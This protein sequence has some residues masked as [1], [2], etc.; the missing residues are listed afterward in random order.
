MLLILCVKHK[1]LH[2]L[3]TISELSLHL[4]NPGLLLVNLVQ[5]LMALLLHLLKLIVKIFGFLVGGQHERHQ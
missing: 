3:I 1:A 4:A 2:Y 5:I